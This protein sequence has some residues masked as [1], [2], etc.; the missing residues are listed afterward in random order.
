MGTLCCVSEQATLSGDML[1]SGIRTAGASNAE[2]FS[3]RIVYG[4]NNVDC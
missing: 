3:Y 1:F 2:F 4:W